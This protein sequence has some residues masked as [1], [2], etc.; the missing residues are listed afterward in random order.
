[1]G[2]SSEADMWSNYKIEEHTVENNEVK[3][4]SEMFVDLSFRI[5]VVYNVFPIPYL[6]IFTHC[7]SLLA[8]CRY[9]EQM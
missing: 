3:K 9:M 8:A 5:K 4:L 7:V 6:G 2:S 1:M